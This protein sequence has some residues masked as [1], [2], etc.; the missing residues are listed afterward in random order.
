MITHYDG[1]FDVS[2]LSRDNCLEIAFYILE[3]IF[4]TI[5]KKYHIFARIYIDVMKGWASGKSEKIN[6]DDIIRALN[7]LPAINNKAINVMAFVAD[8]ASNYG[9]MSV[10]RSEIINI[11]IN[12]AAALSFHYTNSY[13]SS[14]YA[15]YLGKYMAVLRSYHSKTSLVRNPTMI[16]FVDDIV[17]LLALFDELQELGENI[18]E[19]TSVGFRLNL[20]KDYEICGKTHLEL[21][22][23]IIKDGLAIKWLRK[24][25]DNSY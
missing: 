1:Y 14:V 2:I 3:E 22:E 12:G 11:A 18:I 20:P 6:L 15:T 16:N 25:Y 21:A 4:F 5:D 10:V 9:S 7:T 17:S 8:I 23:N 24:L 13:N 19:E